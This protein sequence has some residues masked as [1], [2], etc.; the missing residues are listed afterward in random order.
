MAADAFDREPEFTVGAGPSELAADGHQRT[1]RSA[2]RPSAAAWVALAAIVGAAAWYL[3]WPRDAAVTRPAAPSPEVSPPSPTIQSTEPAIR[4]PVEQI[5][6]TAQAETGE[7]RFP[8]P[9]LDE[10]DVVA[11]DAIETI[12]NGDT[13]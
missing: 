5:A 10:S 7:A 4:H 9:G 2:P 1:A 12:L 8:L 6:S 3:L 11:K 13:F